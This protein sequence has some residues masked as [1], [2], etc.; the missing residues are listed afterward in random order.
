M[1]RLVAIK[2]FVEVA[3]RKSFTQAADTLGISR[4][5]IT[6][7]V[8][9]VESWLNQRLL[10]RTTRKVSLTSAGE[11][12]YIRCQRILDETAAMVFESKLQTEALTGTLRVAA[13][14]GLAQ[15]MLI[16]AILD[17]T[18]RHPHVII[19]IVASDTV[20][21]LV[22]ERLDIALRYTEQPDANLIARKLMSIDSGILATRNYLNQFGEPNHPN[23]LEQHNCLVH[24]QTKSWRLVKGSE[25]FEPNIKGNIRANELA[26][27]MTAACHDKGIIRAPCDLANPLVEQGKLTYILKDYRSPSY[28]LWAVYLSRSY[29][30]PLVRSFIDYLAEQWSED[31]IRPS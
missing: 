24:L 29:Q 31:I 7:H 11:Q 16:H 3:N 2:S 17:F 28:A 18:Q 1:D 6:R 27:L 9:E 30:T 10:H 14:I 19:E 8:Q 5:Q 23:E 13:P 12:A 26:T 25:V 4:L 22:D 15:N 20:S 21:E